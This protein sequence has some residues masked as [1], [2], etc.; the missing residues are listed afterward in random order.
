MK[1][2]GRSRTAPFL[3]GSSVGSSQPP[4]REDEELDDD[5]RL[6]EKLVGDRRV[7]G[8]LEIAMTAYSFLPAGMLNWKTGELTRSKIERV[9][10]SFGIPCAPIPWDRFPKRF[11]KNKPTLELFRSGMTASKI[12]KYFENLIA[13]NQEK[14]KATRTRRRSAA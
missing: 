10:Q 5:A 6:L 9:I 4:S 3:S 2:P 7:L 13:A 1:S 12:E 14:P 11:H 8:L